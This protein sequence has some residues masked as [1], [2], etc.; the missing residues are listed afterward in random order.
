MYFSFKYRI[1]PTDIQK[2]RLSKAFGSS[3]YVYNWALNLKEEAYKNNKTVLI[4]YLQPQLKKLKEQNVWL[5]DVSPEILTSALVNLD[6]AYNNFFN[7]RS[8]HPKMKTRYSSQSFMLHNSYNLDSTKHILHVDGIGDLK[9]EERCSV[10]A[11]IINL[12]VEKTLTEKY[13]AIFCIQ[14]DQ[15]DVEPPIVEKDTSLGLDVGLKNL[16]TCSDGRIF[17]NKAF[18]THT[19]DRLTDFSRRLS[20]KTKG[21]NNY[22]KLHHKFLL[23]HE[24]VRHQRMDYYYKI[25]NELT[26]SPNIK[27][28]CMEDLAVSE[29]MKDKALRRQIVDASF[30]TLRRIIENKCH[31]RNINFIPVGKYAPTSKS[32]N[33]CG[34]INDKLTLKDRR[35]TCPCCGK[36]LDRDFNAACNIRDFGISGLVD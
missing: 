2:N 26:S 17:E 35:W 6:H 3:R 27:T 21:S 24:K 25:A 31:E 23:L 5:Q 12:T 36:E 13:Y 33:H 16:I 28:I 30:F 4:K 29:M 19:L 32:C 18:L 20:K 9:I 14:I 1:Y 7:H 34:Y 10:P 15:E 11:R 8:E 22:K